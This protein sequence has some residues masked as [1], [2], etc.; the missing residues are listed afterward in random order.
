MKSSKGSL[1]LHPFFL[2]SVLLLLL[3]DFYFKYAYHNLL[4]GKL[5]DIAGV[6]AFA[7]FLTSLFP[8]KKKPVF[9]FTALFFIWW[10]SPLSNPII[11]LLNR[12]FLLP[13]NRVIDYTDYIA[14][15]ILPAVYLLKPINPYYKLIYQKIALYSSGMIALFAFCSTSMPR[16]LQRPQN[17]ISVNE[18]YNT[19]LSKEQLLHRMDSLHIN[20]KIDSFVTVP[21]EVSG[22]YH[23]NNI[24]Y[25][26]QKKDSNTKLPQYIPIELKED[27]VLWYRYE[28]Q[29]YIAIDSFVAEGE[30]FP[31]IILNFR[32]YGKDKKISLQ[33]IE[34]DQRQFDAWLN[35]MRKTKKQFREKI[36]R[37]LISRLQK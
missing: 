35:K 28:T 27:E 32:E 23:L 5:S 1:L 20:Y 31:R 13:V 22:Y 4:T 10:K 17:E 8:K 2:A 7:L 16:R 24:Q 12:E 34:T 36:Y 29:P 15:L 33:Y 26:I 30:L 11:D 3:N 18:D 19:R 21:V 9:V 14:L 25:L 37:S 6:T